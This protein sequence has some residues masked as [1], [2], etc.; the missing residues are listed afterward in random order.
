[1]IL[2]EQQK[3]E[4]IAGI[5]PLL[6]SFDELVTEFIGMS[7][8][9]LISNGVT[10]DVNDQ[11]IIGGKKYIYPVKK[12]LPVNHAFKI[13]ELIEKAEDLGEMQESLAE[14]IY[15]YGDKTKF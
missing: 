14:Y 13:S 9:T 3:R 2:P 4:I 1:M 10:T 8:S 7:G 6:L 5:I 11:P 15:M 12:M